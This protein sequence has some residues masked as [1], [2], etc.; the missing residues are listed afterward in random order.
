MD[1]KKFKN[2][3]Y[4]LKDGKIGKRVDLI[5]RNIRVHAF[6][7]DFKSNFIPRYVKYSQHARWLDNEFHQCR[8]TFTYGTILSVVDFAENYTLAPQEEI[9]YQYYNSQQ[10]SIFMHILYTHADDST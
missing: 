1:I 2:L 10:V 8:N 6:M 9:Q 4:A 7:D 5:T 3:E